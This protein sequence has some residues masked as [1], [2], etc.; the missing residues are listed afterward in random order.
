MNKLAAIGFASFFL[1]ANLCQALTTREVEETC[2]IDGEKFKATLAM[3]GTQFGIYLDGKPYG[4]LLAPW[5][6]AKCPTTGFVMYKSKF[7]EDE[8]A[9]LR[10]YVQSSEYRALIGVETTY[11][12]A[13]TLQRRIGED[14]RR[15]AS[16]LLRATWQAE[17]DS[18]YRRY[19]QETLEAYKQ[20]LTQAADERSLLSM[21]FIAGE[22]ERRLG[23]FD[24]A[25][26]RF[27]AL[28]SRDEAKSGTFPQILEFQLTLI[29][30]KDAQ[31]H[32][33]PSPDSPKS[34]K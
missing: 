18:R 10:E 3:S 31:P 8:L 33:V 28:A 5:P 23:L 17:T 25:K 1:V 11:Y 26:R 30:A 22:L 16:T 24:E 9:K 19:A 27:S 4:A 7:S 29:E 14:N 34:E 20:L 32:K 12:L 21:E 2:P 15:I 6:L 13:A